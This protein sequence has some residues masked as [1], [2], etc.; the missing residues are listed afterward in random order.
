MIFIENLNHDFTT[1]ES[2]VLLMY[3]MFILLLLLFGWDLL[4]RYAT[5]DKTTRRGDPA[6]M[7]FFIIAVAMIGYALYTFPATINYFFKGDFE[8][9]GYNLLWLVPLQYFLILLMIIPIGYV[10]LLIL[11]KNKKFI[12]YIAAIIGTISIIYMFVLVFVVGN[13]PTAVNVSISSGAM[14]PIALVIG[15]F[16]FIDFFGLVYILVVKLAP[17]KKVRNQVLLGIVGI[18]IAGIGGAL[19]ISQRSEDRWLYPIGILIELIGFIVMRHFFLSIP[20]YDEFAWKSGMI[21][22]HVI[23][24]ET[25]I[26]LYYKSFAELKEGALNGDVKATVTI[27]ESE[28]PNSDL[29]AGGLVGIKGMLAEISGD[30]G[31]LEN[32]EIGSKSLV[33][34]QGHVALCLLLAEENLGVYHSLL[35]DLVERIELDHPD[36]DNF[37]GDT[38]KIHI[39]PLV[40]EIFGLKE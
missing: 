21:E 24:A 30:K 19:E 27:P 6:Y 13:D 5:T 8:S 32:I 25:G 34:K 31:K 28:R 16:A 17:Q 22:M 4:T 10:C 11:A 20:S 23:I 18:V 38:R 35:E 33:F 2:L 1:I 29:V 9:Q 37:N 40:T 7:I 15:I 39:A 12:A 3:G 14:I 36:L 26:S